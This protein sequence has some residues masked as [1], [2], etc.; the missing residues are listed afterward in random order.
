MFK[1]N[2]QW[3]TRGVLDSVWGECDRLSTTPEPE[4]MLFN[5]TPS[6]H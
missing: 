1:Q 6:L 3:A 5:D 4:N 2:T